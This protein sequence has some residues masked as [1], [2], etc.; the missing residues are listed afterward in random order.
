MRIRI[1]YIFLALLLISFSDASNAENATIPTEKTDVTVGY[2]PEN[3]STIFISSNLERCNGFPAS[4]IDQIKHLPNERFINCVKIYNFNIPAKS[5]KLFSDLIDALN[6][7]NAQRKVTG[8]DDIWS[9]AYLIMFFEC[10]LHENYLEGWKYPNDAIFTE[11]YADKLLLTIDL[12]EVQKS[13]DNQEQ[14]EMSV[15]L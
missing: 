4:A 10:K 2:E 1:S 14:L 9:E 3:S 12:Q 11:N 13:K 6:E 8:E 5:G 7:K 15:R